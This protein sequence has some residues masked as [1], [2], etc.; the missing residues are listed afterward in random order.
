MGVWDIL[1]REIQLSHASEDGDVTSWCLEASGATLLDQC[2]SKSRKGSHSPI[3][4]RYGALG[5]HQRSKSFCGNSFRVSYLVPSR[6]P[7]A[8][9]QRM[10]VVVYVGKH[11]IVTTSSLTYHS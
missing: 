1:T 10:V 8:G 7:R 4:S 3:L 5:F 11:K 9:D 2:T 6:E